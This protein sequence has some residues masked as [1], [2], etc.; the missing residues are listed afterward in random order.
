MHSLMGQ[1]WRV[2]GSIEG[3][4]GVSKSPLMQMEMLAESIRGALCTAD[5]KSALVSETAWVWI[6]TSKTFTMDAC[7]KKKHI[8]WFSTPAFLSPVHICSNN[9]PTSSPRAFLVFTIMHLFPHPFSPFPVPPFVILCI[10]FSFPV[11]SYSPLL[12]TA[13]LF[14][15]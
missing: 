9:I 7:R 2:Q 4:V 15:S 10:L 5:L 12:A 11:S 6:I 13:K 1:R 3:F 8:A 14:T